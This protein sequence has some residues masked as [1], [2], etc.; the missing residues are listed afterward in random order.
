MCL[1]CANGVGAV[2][3][4]KLVKYLT[5]VDIKFD[6]YN[7]GLQGKLNDTVSCFIGDFHQTHS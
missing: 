5:A 7:D 2:A 3:M 6:V 4:S 1:D